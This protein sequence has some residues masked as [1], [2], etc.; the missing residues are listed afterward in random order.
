MDPELE[1]N[2]PEAAHLREFNQTGLGR[3]YTDATS[4][5]TSSL[6]STQRLFT[7]ESEGYRVILHRF[8]GEGSQASL[9]KELWWDKGTPGRSSFNNKS[10]FRD[11]WAGDRSPPGSLG[12]NV[13]LTEGGKKLC[14]HNTVT[15]KKKMLNSS[16][17]FTLES[18]ACSL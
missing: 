13:S 5:E 7:Q 11:G 9:A 8:E 18:A 6:A 3:K 16:K 12:R 4:C 10:C 2:L 17:K 14:H 15:W 1:A